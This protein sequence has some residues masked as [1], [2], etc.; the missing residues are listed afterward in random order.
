[1]RE[2]E[3]KTSESE[4]GEEKISTGKST[5]LKT[6]YYKG[7]PTCGRASQFIEE[8]EDGYLEEVAAT[9]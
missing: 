2:V 9:A 6:R 1:M 5:G 8:S 7:G 4:N 3:T